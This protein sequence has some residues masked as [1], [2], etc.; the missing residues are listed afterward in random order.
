MDRTLKTMQDS[1][2][3]VLQPFPGFYAAICIR[4][5]SVSW[6][7]IVG[8]TSQAI[9]EKNLNEKDSIK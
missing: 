6:E 3:R 7:I 8:A 9:L 5:S 4:L 1:M 2:V